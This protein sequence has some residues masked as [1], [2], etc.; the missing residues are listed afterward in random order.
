ML[1]FPRVVLSGKAVSESHLCPQPEICSRPCRNKRTVS[2]VPGDDDYIYIAQLRIIKCSSIEPKQMAPTTDAS[3]Y[4]SK[5]CPQAWFV[6][7]N[8]K[9]A[10]EASVQHVGSRGV[11][12]KA[13][14][15]LVLA[16][17]RATNG[18]I[19]LLRV[20][21]HDGVRSTRHPLFYCSLFQVWYIVAIAHMVPPPES[22]PC[23]GPPGSPKEPTLNPK[24]FKGTL[25][26]TTP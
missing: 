26:K 9:H 15:L 13:S 2:Q 14:M 23:S 3:I 4:R 17:F 5:N 25:K 24:P 16:S 11:G 10:T 18:L 7:G 19:S 22:P 21:L 8:T 12:H 6:P 1:A 20:G